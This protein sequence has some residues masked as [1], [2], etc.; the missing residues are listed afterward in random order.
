[1]KEQILKQTFDF[2]K[3]YHS[4][5][6]SG[7]DFN[8]INRVYENTC[9]LLESYPQANSFV[10]KM[11][12]LLHDIDDRKLKTDGQNTLRF[13]QSINL[14]NEVLN[15]ILTTIDAISFSKSGANP[16]FSTI[17]MQILSDADKLDAI[18]AVGICRTL[19]FGAS[20][21]TPL[22]NQNIFPEKN[23]TK[24]IY[25][26]LNR[27][28]NNSINHFFDKLLKLKNAM[29]TDTG[30]KEALIRHDFMVSFLKQFFTEQNLINW[31][32]YLDNYLLSQ[33]KQLV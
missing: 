29:Q 7:H 9:K 5:D 26:D 11:S 30:K 23:L 4:K 3:E 17:E 6:K 12:A 24:E 1:M 22:F 27:E 32:E 25:K 13:L 33:E 28:T 31:L 8:H 18:G 2:A 10:V 20:K 19:T 14:E 15:Q 16:Q 21:G